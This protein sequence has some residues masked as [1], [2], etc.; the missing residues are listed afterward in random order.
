MLILTSNIY[1]VILLP[2]F[3]KKSLHHNRTQY[4]Y[5]T[6]PLN[7]FKSSSHIWLHI[8][9][10]YCLQNTSIHYQHSVILDALKHFTHDQQ[11]SVLFIDKIIK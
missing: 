6:N 11:E 3:T 9:T 2:L 4:K 5:I 1:I 10:T 7:F 8:N